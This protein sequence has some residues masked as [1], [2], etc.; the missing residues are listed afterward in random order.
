MKYTADNLPN[1]HDL[2]EYKGMEV[3][4]QRLHITIGERR[5]YKWHLYGRNSG[6]STPFRLLQVFDN[7]QELIN[8]L[9][10]E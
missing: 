3:K 7:E 1:P 4:W 6:A 5:F 8:H 9:N 10:D 2:F